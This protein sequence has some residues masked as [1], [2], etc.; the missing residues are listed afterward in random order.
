MNDPH[1]GGCGCRPESPRRRRVIQ[2]AVAGLVAPVGAAALGTTPGPSAG[3]RLVEEDAEGAPSPLRAVDL[4]YGKP[5]LAFPL[6]TARNA[7]RDETRLNKVLLIRFLESDLAPEVRARAANGVLAFSS[8]CTHQGCDIKTWSAK[9][10]V[11]LCFC[12]SSKFRLLEEGVVAGGPATRPLP[13][14]PLRMDGDFLA[15]AGG[16]SAPPGGQPT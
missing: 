15:V 9:E 5:V 4:P 1:T 13:T 7:L 3:D 16:F 6:D 14:L 11:A 12:H 10:Q 8:V 2:L